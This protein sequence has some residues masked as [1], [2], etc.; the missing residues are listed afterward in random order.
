[1]QRDGPNSYSSVVSF[2]LL[3]TH[4]SLRDSLHS[5]DVAVLFQ[6]KIAHY[7]ITPWQ[8][9]ESSHRAQ[10]Y[11]YS[12]HRLHVHVR[13]CR[14]RSLRWDTSVTLHETPAAM[15]RWTPLCQWYGWISYVATRRGRSLGSHAGKASSSHISKLINFSKFI[16][17]PWEKWTEI[18]RL[19]IDENYSALFAI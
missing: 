6:F 7:H 19:E 1:M 9:C 5:C 11:S 16:P 8:H 15:V 3:L 10:R 2:V 18:N 12:S 14:Q 17:S 4:I 13:R